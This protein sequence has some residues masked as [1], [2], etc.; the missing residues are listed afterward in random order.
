[1]RSMKKMSVM[2]VISCMTAA[3][4]ALTGMGTT[5]S[6]AE[7]ACTTQGTVEF[8]QGTGVTKPVDPDDPGT[9]VK[10]I[11]PDG[12]EPKEGTSGPLSI[13]FASSIDFGSNEISNKDAV[14][15]A[16]PQKIIKEEKTENRANYVQVSDHRGS[17]AGWKL[18]LKQNGQLKNDAALN[19]AL[20]GAVITIEKGSTVSASSDTVAKPTAYQVILNPAGDASKVMEAEP[21]QG[22]MTWI[23]KFGNLET[24]DGVLKNTGISLSIPGSAPKDAVVYSTTLTWTLSVTP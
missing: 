7:S 13:D 22:S 6:A 24:V 16:E 11:N 17:N 2:K 8:E 14:Y 9:E 4:L 23:D 21:G 18:T 19:A 5:A 15:Y 3:A 20:D 10:P 1:M 12:S